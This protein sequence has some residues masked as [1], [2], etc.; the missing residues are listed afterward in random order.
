MKTLKTI[1][2]IFL[3]LAV[4]VSC[5][6]K[7]EPETSVNSGTTFSFISLTADTTTIPLGGE[8][9]ITANA[10]GDNLTYTWSVNSGSTIIGSGS[11]VRLNASCP[12]CVGPNTVTCSVKG[13]SNATDTKTIIITV[14]N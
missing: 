5:K 13:G 6:K 4:I 14:T 11:Q 10:T 8:V 12:S 3:F 2:I 9:K 7:E 1:G